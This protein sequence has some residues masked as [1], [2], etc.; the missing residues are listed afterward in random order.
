MKGSLAESILLGLAFSF[1]PAVG[2]W[3]IPAVGLALLAERV[4]VRDLAKVAGLTLL[5]SLPG[6]IPLIGDQL[7]AQPASYDDWQFI[8]TKHMPFH[9]DPFYFSTLGMV[10][11]GLM[12]IFNSLRYERAESSALRFLRNFQIAIAGFF[13]LGIVLRAFE[14]YPLL[15]FMPMRLFPI[16]TPLFFVFSAFYF[17][18]KLERW[19]K[20]A[21]AAA[22][23]LV[24]LGLLQPFDAGI[25][26]LRELKASWVAKADDREVSLKWVAE[27]TPED[28]VILTAPLGREFWHHSQRSQIVS[29]MYPRYDRLSEWRSRIGDLTSDVQIT[30]RASSRR[31]ID[32]AF[33]QLSTTQIEDLRRTYS[34]THLVTRTDYPF[35][36]LFRTETYKVYQLP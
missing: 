28:A 16:L 6:I 32:A 34:T 33:A 3:A 10:L 8:V 4:A 36:V 26:R 12:L 21:L 18:E 2:L 7:S 19:P 11:L 22:Y 25:G 35:P 23:V 17:V 24:I 31:E 15:R 20:K 1:H 14:L 27:N 30:D 9:F 13:V 29:Y 5:F